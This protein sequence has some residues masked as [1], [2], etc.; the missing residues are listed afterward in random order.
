MWVVLCRISMREGLPINQILKSYRFRCVIPANF[1][2]SYACGIAIDLRMRFRGLGS[3]H[4]VYGDWAWIVRSTGTGLGSF[5]PRGLGTDRVCKL[6]RLRSDH[7]YS[8]W[9]GG[10]SGRELGVRAAGLLIQ[11]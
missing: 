5:G 9:L 6:T 11:S 7:L 2:S 10:R 4:T 8:D 1:K 3:D